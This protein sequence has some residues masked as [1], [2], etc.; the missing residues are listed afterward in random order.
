LPS[1]A[2]LYATAQKESR[3]R[4]CPWHNKRVWEPFDSCVVYSEEQ[5]TC[6]E[7]KLR[8]TTEYGKET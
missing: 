1:P 7:I 6:G 5:G 2:A 4:A 3:S 8:Y